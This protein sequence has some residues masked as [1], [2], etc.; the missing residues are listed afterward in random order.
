MSNL[1]DF[2]DVI[3]T[4]AN[5]SFNNTTPEVQGVTGTF[6]GGEI[7]GIAA[8]LIMIALGMKMKV[9]ADLLAVST[10]SMLAVVTNSA[11][12]AAVLPDF[13]FWLFVLGGASVFA[14][15]L[16]KFIKYR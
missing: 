15:G 4:G 9:S 14:M 3:A 1:T 16:I 6:G 7:L 13:V 12:G 11:V 8:I 5:V 10:I 2:V